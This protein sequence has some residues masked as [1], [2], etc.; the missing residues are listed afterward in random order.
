MGISIKQSKELT[1]EERLA[2]Q[3]L[4]I[5]SLRSAF[6][7]AFN[8]KDPYHHELLVH[9]ALRQL[10]REGV[11]KPPRDPLEVMRAVAR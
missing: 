4:K 1:E 6:P 3:D 5:R 10:L 11:V 7:L 9:K 2:L 8:I